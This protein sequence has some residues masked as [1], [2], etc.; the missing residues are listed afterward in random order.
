MGEAELQ[1]HT[2]LN[3]APDRAELSASSTRR[4]TPSIYMIKRMGGALTLLEHCS[5]KNNPLP[6]LGI[7]PQFIGS[8]ARS[9]VAK[10]ID[11]SLLL[12]PGSVQT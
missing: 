11:P 4:F 9:L 10:P 8:P 1:L 3:S 12:Y 7:E 5:E 2:F 6:L